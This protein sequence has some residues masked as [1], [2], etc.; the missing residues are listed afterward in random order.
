MNLDK[1]RVEALREKIVALVLKDPRKAAMILAGWIQPSPALR[2]G[3]R[4]KE[5]EEK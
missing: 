4:P 2:P 5:G 3:P 1:K